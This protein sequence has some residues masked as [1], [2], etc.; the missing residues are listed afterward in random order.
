MRRIVT[1]IKDT[2]S[3]SSQLKGYNI[4]KQSMKLILITK[5][6]MK[7]ILAII[8]QTK[9]N[10][11]HSKNSFLERELKLIRNSNLVYEKSS[12]LFLKLQK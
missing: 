9:S 10:V 4:T 2:I 6:S 8:S 7:L 11:T 1:L 3:Q 12:E 5:Q